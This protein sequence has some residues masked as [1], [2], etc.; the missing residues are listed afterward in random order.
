MSIKDES[1]IVCTCQKCGRKFEVSPLD[2]KAV[3]LGD[4]PK[5]CDECTTSERRRGF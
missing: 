4:Y 5:K 3:Y 1:K 2:L